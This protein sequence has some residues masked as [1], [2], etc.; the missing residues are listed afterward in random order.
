ME[1]KY[2][3]EIIVQNKD[4]EWVDKGYLTTPSLIRFIVGLIKA[5]REYDYVR[6]IVRVK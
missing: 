4:G 3:I 1:Y 5:Y 6:A 2:K